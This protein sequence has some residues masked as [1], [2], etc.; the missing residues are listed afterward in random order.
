MRERD[1]ERE[2]HENKII[3]KCDVAPIKIS[4]LTFI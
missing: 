4:L 3:M 2:Y 1:I